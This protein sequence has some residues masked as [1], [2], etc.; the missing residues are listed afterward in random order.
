MLLNWKTLSVFCIA[1]QTVILIHAEAASKETVDRAEDVEKVLIRP[2]KLINI[3]ST[4]HVEEK[5]FFS[6]LKAKWNKVV[7]KAKGLLVTVL[8]K[9]MHTKK[10][11]NP[12]YRD[13]GCFNYENNMS[14]QIGGPQSPEEVQATFY[15]FHN[16]STDLDDLL[17]ENETKVIPE[18][19]YT[20]KN[21]TLERTKD[22][23]S[24]DMPL[25]VVTHGL[26]GN[27][28]TPWMKPLVKALLENVNCTV[29]V[30]DWEKG[31][32]GSYPDAGINTPMA[33]ALM[34][35]FL[36]KVVTETKN[37]IGPKNIT[38]IGFSMG[39]QVMGFAGRHFQ[40]YTKEKLK[41]ITGLDPAGWLYEH[42]TATLTK[43]DADYVD[44][45]HTNAGSIKN[46]RIGLGQSVGHVDFYP[47]GG[48]VQTGCKN[49]PNII[50]T[51]YMEVIT[52]SHYKATDLFIE[53]LRN[54]TC[55][56]KSYGCKSWD[57]FRSGNCTQYLPENKT[58]LLGFYSD[59]APGRGDQFLYTNAKSPYC[60]GNNTDPPE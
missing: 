16:A 3:F 2:R 27:K 29:L 21:W 35:Q 32:A 48:T 38:L 59:T 24:T 44:V 7:D 11:K 37:K 26:T 34:S 1:I 45:I 36:Q 57:D 46:F 20:F 54:R 14:L 31:A 12:C 30:M 4:R 49:A 17:G 8:L 55:Q 33:G 13:L 22:T 9:I 6:R 53:S 39:A 28:R 42:T 23:L 25:I 19:T 51:N 56:F 18:K 15:F 52:C 10:I 47:N 58:G 60:R 43:D 5:S 41:R 40:N 50:P